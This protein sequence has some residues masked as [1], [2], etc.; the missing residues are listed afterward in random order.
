M[1]KR[2]SDELKDGESSPKKRCA[3]PGSSKIPVLPSFTVKSEVPPTLYAFGAR[4]VP[5][6]DDKQKKEARSKDSKKDDVSRRASKKDESSNTVNEKH[7]A[8]LK[9]SSELMEKAENFKLQAEIEL[10]NAKLAQAEEREKKQGA[11]NK[12]L[13]GVNKTQQEQIK[14]QQEQMKDL[15]EQVK[16][17]TDQNQSLVA[18]L[19]EPQDKKEKAKVEASKQSS[20]DISEDDSKTVQE[21]FESLSGGFKVGKEIE[22]VISPMD[23]KIFDDNT[24]EH[25]F[26]TCSKNWTKF[27]LH[28]VNS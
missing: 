17:L 26:A 8:L 2:E 6:K 24:T 15:L 12:M 27:S 16:S 23:L 19:K 22:Y 28:G 3:G 20:D 9:H 14:T 5:P 11:R 1:S 10:L 21:L 4:V 13:S 25:F 18:K 7:A